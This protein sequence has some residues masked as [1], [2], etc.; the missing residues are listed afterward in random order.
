MSDSKL[1]RWALIDIETSGIDPSKDSIIDV[2]FL[3][4]EGTKLVREYSS[5][6]HYEYKL[7][8][9][10]Q[11]LTGITTKMVS[12]APSWEN[13][14]KDVLDLMGCALLAHNSDFEKSFLKEYFDKIAGNY[15][16]ESYED[17]IFYLALLMPGRSIFNLESFITEWGIRKSEVHRGYEDSVDLL[18]VLLIATAQVKKDKGLHQ[19]I[20]DLFLEYQ[21]T[22]YWYYHFFSLAF[23]Q[24]DEIALQIDFDLNEKLAEINRLVKPDEASAVA[25]TAFKK[26]FSGENI[27]EILQNQEE[28]QKIIPAYQFRQ[29]QMEL[30]HKVGQ[31]FKNKIHCLV[32]A[33]TG[34]G[35]TFGYLLP[36]LLYAIQNDE[37]QILISTGT[38]TLQHQI[39]KKDVPLIKKILGPFKNDVRIKQLVGSGN[40]YCELIFR[41]TLNEQDLFSMSNDFEE[42]YLK[43][44]FD[45]IFYH[46]SVASSD[47]IFTKDN[48]PYVIKRS[49]KKAA[50]LEREIL[51]DFRSCGG[52]K[53]PFA[54]DCSYI[55]GL[56]AAKEASIIIGNHALMFTWPK[57]FNR[58]GNII[59]D[60]AHK[61]E[62]EATKAYTLEITKD[63]LS[64]IKSSFENL[65]GVGAL[66]YLLARKEER[67]GE[68]TAIINDIKVKIQ[69]QATVLNDHLSDLEELIEKLF[70]TKS[71]YTDLYWNETPMITPKDQEGV[72]I[73]IRNH[74]EA[75]FLSFKEIYKILT[76]YISKWTIDQLEDE[77][78]ILAFTRFEKFVGPIEDHV[79]SFAQLLSDNEEYSKSI[80]FH[81]EYGYEF[82]AVPINIG[83]I[84]HDQLLETSTSVV[85]T[86]ATLGNANGDSGSKGIEWATGY[87]YLKPEKRFKTGFY[88]PA[89]YDYEHKTK[90]FVCD[91]VPNFYQKDFVKVVLAPIIKLIRDI[92]GRSLL[93]FSARTRFEVAREIMLS[94]FEGE[95]PLFIQD[96]GNFVV[97]EFKKSQMGILLGMESFGEGIDIPGDTLQFIFVDK[98]PDL[99][100]ELVIDKR[101]DFFEKSIGNEFT[102]Y[103]LSHR[104]RSL[105]QKL[106]RL[107][108]TDQD[109]GGVI[110]VDARIKTWKKSTFDK[111]TNL[112]KPYVINRT[113]LSDACAHVKAFIKPEN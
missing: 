9:F 109:F 43:M 84:V 19:R 46:N 78:E 32:Q 93:L 16:R 58:P 113:N 12:D 85:M 108:R 86:S 59:V 38:K 64:Q 80:R 39:M 83:K 6:V 104:S 53:C 111:F 8:H 7:S 44:Y 98:I 10:I 69:E 21:L 18:K 92:N 1:G 105:H 110:I 66:F 28:I 48:F 31:S 99:R 2:G 56:K 3:E 51:V 103:Y 91:D 74:V 34:T 30:A 107:L 72:S 14:S 33:P 95:I 65:Q 35:K 17:S 40:H 41:Q 96:M 45:L 54:S 26:E 62:N 97:E 73:G 27:K 82:L 4:F 25:M 37:S 87:L 23:E 90:I 20:T 76:P 52:W 15:K 68:S 101:R 89:V 112:M 94:E 13:V 47:D 36:S 106:G 79:V 22:D 81:E 50:K 71:R 75:L 88:L 100:Q 57:G 42:N 77:K 60:E 11:K 61:I 49:L 24:L 67:V 29:T 63:S 70:K 102:D 55:K 5:L